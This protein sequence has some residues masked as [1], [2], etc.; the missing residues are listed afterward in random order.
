MLSMTNEKGEKV[1]LDYQREENTI[2]LNLQNLPTGSYTVMLRGKQNA[3]AVG[4]LIAV[5]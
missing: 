4:K 1:Q 3:I 5:D 2:L